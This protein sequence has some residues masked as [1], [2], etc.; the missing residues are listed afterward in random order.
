MQTE[1]L[2][3]QMAADKLAELTAKYGPIRTLEVA[4]DDEGTTFVKAY[5]KELTLPIISAAVS[6]LESDPLKAAKTL[7]DSCIVLEASDPLFATDEDVKQGAYNEVMAETFRVRK[8][9]K[10]RDG[11]NYIIEV[12]KDDEG[13]EA[14][15]A[16]VSKP[17][18]QVISKA[19]TIDSTD[20]IGAALFILASCADKAQTAPEFF[21]DRDVILGSVAVLR[22]LLKSR[23][24]VI[25]KNF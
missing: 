6:M 22:D 7:F 5:L 23:A 2:I 1:D 15:K 14:F 20:P 11:L 21:E 24:A 25:K 17:S 16:V 13:V 8:G 4:A 10:R 12:P 18:H 3:K 9:T 19:L